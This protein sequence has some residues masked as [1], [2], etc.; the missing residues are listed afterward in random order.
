LY[1]AYEIAKSKN[2]P[3]KLLD[4]SNILLKMDPL[5]GDYIVKYIEA[6]KLNG[7]DPSN[8]LIEKLSELQKYNKIDLIQ[9]LFKTYPHLIPSDK[10]Q[11][12]ERENLLNSLQQLSLADK[13]K[14]LK[15]YILKY[16]KDEEIKMIYLSTIIDLPSYYDEAYSILNENFDM[17]LNNKDKIDT[18]LKYKIYKL[19]L[20][21][22]DF[23]K[24]ILIY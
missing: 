11:Q 14:L 3:N 6:L 19:F 10:I 24:I 18:N 22:E 12:I 20:M 13:I 9:Y 16:P 15:D 2:I 23:E 17:F 21:K 8:F 7:M 1:K 4:I 5:N